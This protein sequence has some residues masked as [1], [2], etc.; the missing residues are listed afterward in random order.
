MRVSREWNWVLYNWLLLISIILWILDTFF[1]VPGGINCHALWHITTGL[2]S[3][4]GMR[5]K[6]KYDFY[7]GMLKAKNAREFYLKNKRGGIFSQ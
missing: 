5:I 1:C 6:D 7:M 2:A 3:H 4:F